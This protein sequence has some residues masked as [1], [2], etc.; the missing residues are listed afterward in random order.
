MD[1]VLTNSDSVGMNEQEMITLLKFWEGNREVGQAQNSKPS[2]AEI[3]DQTATF[4]ETQKSHGLDIS[5]VHLHP[6][7]SFIL[8]YDE[9]KWESGIDSLL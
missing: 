1:Y 3:L 7:G 6:Y 8:C 9:N 5:R 2:L 4:F